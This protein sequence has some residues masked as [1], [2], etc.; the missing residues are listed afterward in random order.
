MGLLIKTIYSSDEQSPP[1]VNK[2]VVGYLE[3]DQ[4]REIYVH[5]L[6]DSDKQ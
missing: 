2:I 5:Y 4:E 3:K 6:S 1:E